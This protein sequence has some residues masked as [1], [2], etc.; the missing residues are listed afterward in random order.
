MTTGFETLEARLRANT[1]CDWLS[2]EH[3]LA[4]ALLGPRPVRLPAARGHASVLRH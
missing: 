2:P 3:A 4:A 1:G